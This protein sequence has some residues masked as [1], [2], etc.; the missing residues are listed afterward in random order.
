M[1][2]AMWQGHKF[3][4]QT[5]HNMARNMRRLCELHAHNWIKELTLPEESSV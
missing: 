3:C 1:L 5:L 2:L 4:T